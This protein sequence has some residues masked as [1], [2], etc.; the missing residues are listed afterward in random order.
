ME[1]L[2]IENLCKVYGK[3]ENRLPHWTMFH[4]QSKRGTLPQSSAPPVPVNP[5]YFMLLRAW[6]C[7]QAERST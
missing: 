5:H 1:F 7:L 6:M 2:K 3:G 4:S